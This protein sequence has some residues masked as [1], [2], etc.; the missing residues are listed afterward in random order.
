MRERKREMERGGGRKNLEGGVEERRV[1]GVGEGE[2][3]RERQCN[4]HDSLAP[5]L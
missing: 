5:C 3:E 4:N 2:R 1:G